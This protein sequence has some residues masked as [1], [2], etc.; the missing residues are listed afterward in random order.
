MAALEEVRVISKRRSFS[1]C[2][3][4]HPGSI[5][6]RRAI[7]VTLAGWLEAHVVNLEPPTGGAYI[8]KWKGARANVRRMIAKEFQMRSHQNVNNNVPLSQLP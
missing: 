7:N 6:G 5:F 2:Q 4:S 1:G 3:T 8:R